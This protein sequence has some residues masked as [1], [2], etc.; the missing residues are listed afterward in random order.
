M[1]PDNDEKRCLWEEIQE[2]QIFFMSLLLTKD[3]NNSTNK[4]TSNGL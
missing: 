3:N 1:S 2:K 4:D